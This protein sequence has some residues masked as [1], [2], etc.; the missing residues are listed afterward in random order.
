MADIARLIQDLSSRDDMVRDQAATEIY[1]IGAATGDIA[2]RDW[3]RV[4]ELD[5]T[6]SR[7]PTVGVAVD[8]QTFEEIRAAMDIQRLAAVPPDQDAME[9]EFESDSGEARLDVLTTKAPGDGGAIDK[10][11]QKF[12]AGIQ[13]IEYQVPDV[14]RAT[15][16]LRERFGIKPIYPQTRDGAD[17]TRVNFFLVPIPDG[18]KVLIELVEERIGRSGH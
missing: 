9:F 8:P 16:L 2:I 18:K 11:L 13:Q 12:G 15:Q 6:F 7:G 10:F 14:D 3:R 1:R 17:G 4:P 5:K